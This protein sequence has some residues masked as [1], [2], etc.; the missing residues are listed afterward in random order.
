M[1][2]PIEQWAA[3]ETGLGSMLSPET[4]R[5]WQFE[6]IGETIGYALAGSRFY[7]EKLEAYFDVNS[8]RNFNVDLAVGS[9]KTSE[10]RTFTEELFF[11]LPFTTASDIACAPMDFLCVPPNKVERVATLY[12]SGTGGVPKRIFFSERDLAST[13]KFF[14]V[15][16][17]LMVEKGD[18]SAIFLPGTGEHGVAD[19]LKKALYDLG[20]DGEAL[21]CIVDV[22]EAAEKAAGKDCLVGLPAELLRL[23][24]RAP[25]LR[26]KS[27][28]LTA[29]YVPKSVVETI[30]ETW[31]A[32]VFSHFGMTE[33]GMGCGVD[34]HAHR[35]MH[36]RMADIFLEIVDP[37]S[38]CP[39][40][41]GALGEL[42]LT[43]LR[44]EAMPLIRY[45]TGDMARLSPAGAV[46]G[47]GC[48]LPVL[49]RIYGRKEDFVLP[50]GG[51][52]FGICALEEF[53]FA[54]PE[55]SDFSARWVPEGIALEIETMESLDCVMLGQQLMRAFPKQG[56][57]FVKCVEHYISKPGKRRME[58]TDERRTG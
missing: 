30:E 12:T 35:G 51:G 53:L 46:C 20:V 31:K 39:L 15:G 21:G 57:F 16:M 1:Y 37:E 23:C 52:I 24:R 42:V 13:R 49:E 34:C 56:K 9:E 45:R 11:S 38:G 2:T 14:A 55:I 36:V 40:P 29:D 10:K 44:R 58:K 7:R 5:R 43:T 22:E 27:V 19:L 33:T 18:T 4:L 41:F 48:E 32:E 17:S 6:Q 54:R 26:P 8:D 28:L 50:K 47:C 25:G 3:D